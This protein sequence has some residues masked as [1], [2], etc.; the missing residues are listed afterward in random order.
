MSASGQKGLLMATM[1]PPAT[2]EEE[3]QDWYDTEHVPER[4]LYP[5]FETVARWVCLDGWP[6]WLATYDLASVDAVRTPEYLSSNG[7]KA[8]PWSRRILSRLIGRRRVVASQVWPGNEIC[9]TPEKISRLLVALYPADTF[10]SNGITPPPSA[11]RPAQ[12][13]YFRAPGEI[14]LLAA[15]DRPVVL[16]ELT[17]AYGSLNGSGANLFNLYMPYRRS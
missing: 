14:W 13:R 8:T 5:G 12:L 11:L 10:D 3:F 2:M 9:L 7:D 17:A 15:F 1:E 6:R 16:S 4:R